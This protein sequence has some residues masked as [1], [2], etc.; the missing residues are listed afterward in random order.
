MVHYINLRDLEPGD[1]LFSYIASE[2]NRPGLG[3]KDTPAMHV[4]MVSKS[5]IKFPMVPGNAKLKKSPGFSGRMVGAQEIHAAVGGR[6]THGLVQSDVRPPLKSPIEN[7][8]FEQTSRVLRCRNKPLRD[9]AINLA[10]NW[11]RY[12]TE[13]A[14]GRCEVATVHEKLYAGKPETFIDVQR[15]L[16]DKGGKFRAI[17]YAARRN[18]PLCYPQMDQGEQG[19]FCSMFVATCFQVAGLEA[20]V[21]AADPTDVDQRVSD[22]KINQTEWETLRGMVAQGGYNLTEEDLAAYWAYTESLRT[23]MPYEVGAFLEKRRKGQN[24]NLRNRR[25]D[26][27][28]YLPSLLFWR[29]SSPSIAACNWANYITAGMKLDAKIIMPTGLFESLNADQAGWEDMGALLGPGAFTESKDE[30]ATRI[31]QANQAAK[32]LRTPFYQKG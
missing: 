14:D 30:R 23:F 26:V 25:K 7:G 31:S 12:Q 19:M 13:Y 32:D 1:L 15:E 17:K 21:A 6:K 8:G 29:K 3:A 24:K 5:V 18:G 22:K 28:F 16:F 2:T 10:R 27:K 9:R 20:L 4:S 11:L